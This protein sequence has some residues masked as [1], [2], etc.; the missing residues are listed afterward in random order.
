MNKYLV[1]FTFLLLATGACKREAVPTVSREDIKRLAIKDIDFDYFTARSRVNYNDGNN[2]I[3]ATANIRMKKDSIIWISV[4][5]GFGIE[6]ARGLV[7]QDSIFLM[8]KLE[9]SYFAYSFAELSNKLNVNLSYDVLQ[10]ALIGDM[11]RPMDRR[12]RIERQEL[13]TVVIQQEPMVDIANYISHEN[14]KLT[15]VVL[16][17]KTALNSL[18][19]DYDDFKILDEKLLPFSSTISANYRDNQQLKTTTIAFKHNKAEFSE[20]ALSFPFDIPDKYDRKN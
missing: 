12:N 3:G 14:M 7:T 15:K 16:Q 18:I 9:K 1:I 10:S 11:I 4:S 20:N 19:L 5:P 13:Q 2:N 6:A 17:D 8:N